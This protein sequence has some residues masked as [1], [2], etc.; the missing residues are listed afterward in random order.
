[1]E[2]AYF[3]VVG[4]LKSIR[5]GGGN[6]P[7]DFSLYNDAILLPF[8][9]ALEELHPAKGYAELDQVSLRVPKISDTLNTKKILGPTIKALH[10][11]VDDFEIVAPEEILEKR[12]AAQSIMNVVLTA[13]AAI[14]LIVGG[15][16]VM[17]IMLA[18]I[19][20]RIAE[21]GLRRAIG[22]RKKDIRNQFL[23]ESVIICFIGGCIGIVLGLL[24]S[25]VVA[26][27]ASFPIAFAWESMALAFVIS[28]GVGLIFGMVPAMRAA[29]VNPIE[30]LQREAF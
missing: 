28:V 10:G 4:I 24:I 12:Q 13:I 22:A 9:T 19:M 20:E 21:I 1:L 6:L 27:L 15:I 17:N 26:H 18:N 14:S 30:A 7:I 8:C 5:S 29:Q 16:G 11:G 3:E 25:F 23:L 2:Y